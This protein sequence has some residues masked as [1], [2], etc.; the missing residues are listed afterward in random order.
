MGKQKRYTF[1]RVFYK[2]ENAV[3]GI[4]KHINTEEIDCETLKE[5]L[6]LWRCLNDEEKS[7]HPHIID[8]VNNKK[9][10]LQPQNGIEY[11]NFLFFCDYNHFLHYI[12]D[13]LHELYLEGV[14]LFKDTSNSS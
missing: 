13:L 10:F 14:Q 12:I 3:W 7:L 1:V 6:D 2:R 9:R 5:A 4:E 8:K 11:E